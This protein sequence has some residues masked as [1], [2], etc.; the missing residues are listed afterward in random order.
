MIKVVTNSFVFKFT[1]GGGEGRGRGCYFCHK[2]SDQPHV[3][4]YANCG[5]ESDDFCLFVCLPCI[6]KGLKESA[7]G[8]ERLLSDAKKGEPKKQ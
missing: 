6:T 5:C 7:E 1:G 4:V 8:W 2:F 3:T